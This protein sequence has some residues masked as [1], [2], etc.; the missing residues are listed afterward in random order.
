MIQFPLAFIQIEF[1]KDFE[2]PTFHGLC[3]G[4]NM[5]QSRTDVLYVYNTLQHDSSHN[6]ISP[7]HESRT[8]RTER[9]TGEP[10]HPFISSC[11]D[12]IPLPKRALRES[13]HDLKL[14][15]SPPCAPHDYIF[16]FTR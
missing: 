5:L 1:L 7:V 8:Q 15:L 4:V 14:A 9:I 16:G 13:P 10:N 11:I 2:Y 3:Q 6:V 12:N